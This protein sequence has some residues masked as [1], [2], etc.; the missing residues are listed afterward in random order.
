MEE[1]DGYLGDFVSAGVTDQDEIEYADTLNELQS[2]PE[3]RDS[4]AILE[5]SQE[6]K[7]AE[8]APLMD[9]SPTRFRKKPKDYSAQI[10]EYIPADLRERLDVKEKVQCAK[11]EEPIPAPVR[12][13]ALD[14]FALLNR[15]QYLK[16]SLMVT[17]IHLKHKPSR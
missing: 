3:I 14:I 5:L 11:T 13:L 2:L 9:C 8:I 1:L 16:F 7:P 17:I 12:E 4:F 10:R 6:A 15:N